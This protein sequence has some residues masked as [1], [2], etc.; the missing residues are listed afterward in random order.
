MTDGGRVS[1]P[2]A[3]KLRGSL[4]LAIKASRVARVAMP[5][6]GA[7][8]LLLALVAVARRT[9]AGTGPPADRGPAGGR[10][11]TAARSGADE[12][13]SAAQGQGSVQGGSLVQKPRAWAVQETLGAG[14]LGHED[15]SP[16]A[17]SAQER[18]PLL[19]TSL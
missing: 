9:R 14:L 17:A 12:R 11:D 2:T 19:Q 10:R 1:A 15:E 5:A 4:F 6:V 13:E 7:V 18:T 16:G 3:R 8:L